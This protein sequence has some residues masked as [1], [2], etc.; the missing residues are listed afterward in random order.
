MNWLAHT[1]TRFLDLEEIDLEDTTYLVPCFS[2]LDVLQSSVARLGIVHPPILQERPG[3]R[4][5]PVL[6][7]RRLTVA[8]DLGMSRVEVRTIPSEMP[9]QD[10]FQLAF[11]DNIACRTFDAACTA[12]VVKRLLEIFPRTEVANEFLPILHVPQHGPRLERLQ[13]VGGLELPV[14][15]AMAAGRIH[16]KDRVDSVQD[17]T[18]RAGRPAETL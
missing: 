4:P 2:D 6:G 10:G 11:W 14:L 13:A 3:T 16:E 7:R 15:G 17:A 1:K 12:M 9:V 18:P 8:R 5:I